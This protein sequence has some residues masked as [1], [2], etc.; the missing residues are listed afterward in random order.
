VIWYCLKTAPLK[1]KTVQMILDRKGIRTFLPVETKWK[2]TGR[3]KKEPCTY[4]LIP[5]YL[6]AGAEQQ[7]PW[8][9][10]LRLTGLPIT[11]VVSFDGFPAEIP[12]DAIEKLGKLSGNSFAT[13]ETKVHKSFVPGDVVTIVDGAFKDWCVPVESINGP[14]ATVLLE[15]FGT[16][17][18]VDVPMTSLEA[19]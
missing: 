10:V 4:P 9:D 19:A 16:T 14:N 15:L 5:R 8:H 6:F 18:E 2:R 17:R 13:R 12:Q 1:E 3:H 11:G 7:F